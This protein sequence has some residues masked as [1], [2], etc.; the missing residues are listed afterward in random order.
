MNN[1]ISVWLFGA[2]LAL[3]AA[4]N[5][6]SISSRINA[7]LDQF[8]EPAVADAESGDGE[9]QAMAPSAST[10]EDAAA[11]SAP[12]GE[13]ETDEASEAGDE[14]A[15]A[16]A[17]DTPDATDTPDAGD[18][19]AGETDST[20]S[21]DDGDAA[22]QAEVVVPSFG[23]LRVEPDGSTLV[24]GQAGPNADVEVLSGSETLA[25]AK[26]EPN[27]DFVA[28]LDEPLPPG[29]YEI[30]LR[31]IEEDGDVAMSEE[32]AIVSV[33]EPGREGELL[34][35]VERP[36]APSRLINTP[37][38]DE[39]AAAESEVA[40]AEMP[41]SEQEVAAET[42]Q[43]SASEPEGSAETPS[44]AADAEAET[45]VAAVET[46]DGTAP[47]AS[48][49]V[50]ETEASEDGDA[51]GSTPEQPAVPIRIEAVEIDNEI[52]FVAGSAS[53]GVQVRVYANEFLLGDT[54]ASPG[55]RFLVEVRRE[56]AIGDYII[57]AD[58]ID[59]ATADVIARA[60][61]PFTRSEGERL[62]AIAE[63]ATP[64]SAAAAEPAEA[65]E[66]SSEPMA[67]SETAAASTGNEAEPE[68]AASA[69]SVSG[70]EQEVTEPAEAATSETVAGDTQ[71][72]A[73]EMAEAETSGD[74][75]AEADVSAAA[76]SEPADEPAPEAATA[77]ASTETDTASPFAETGN[78]PA[79]ATAEA[80]S[81]SEPNAET[82]SAPE[83]A[84]TE[85]AAETDMASAASETAPDEPGAAEADTAA[86]P[87]VEAQTV[88]A[89]AE[90]DGPPEVSDDITVTGKLR[91]TESSVIIR[92]GDTLWHIS[93]RVY[94][95]GTRYTTIYLA[96][97]DQ[98]KD[99][100]R[101]WPG[102]IFALPED[103]EPQD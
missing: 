48:D 10:E 91:Q 24:A 84:T 7:Y 18:T 101:I 27:G 87:A 68:E 64:P 73:P 33:P 3:V 103:A 31:S 94:G 66:A 9:D 1:K 61:V 58:V 44:P 59:P 86:Q 11:E 97:Q 80:G 81:A 43:E 93:R 13:A 47:D 6:P 49:E 4:A 20:Q 99:P 16:D 2:V 69:E 26:A 60:A 19:P 63:D 53:P 8:S 46:Q 90:T 32:T 42:Q 28:V 56:L 82:A 30:V 41:E 35:L 78:E 17:P 40:A 37:E 29:D 70:A 89:A 76:A 92:R 102:Q 34:A 38:A 62:A 52:V 15:Q 45:E 67:E 21:P 57:R 100:D 79:S 12:A 95:E 22:Q 23:L 55:G 71:G 39:E 36:G 5:T 54:T 72:T 96:N 25:E 83:A 14:A 65:E 85:P 77:E 74:E 75:G 88:I 50:A 51:A 98:I